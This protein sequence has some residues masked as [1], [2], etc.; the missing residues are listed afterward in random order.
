[1]SRLAREKTLDA[2]AAFEEVGLDREADIQATGQR[3][4]NTVLSL[5]GSQ[6]PA[7]V[8][9]SFRGRTASTDALVRHSG[10]AAAGR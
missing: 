4:R 2:F 10:L 1:M 8:Y 9:K 7:D 5:G 6:R 3:F